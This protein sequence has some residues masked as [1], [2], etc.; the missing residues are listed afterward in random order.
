MKADDQ[1]V[2]VK[3]KAPHPPAKWVPALTFPGHP[4]TVR[5]SR[6]FEL[7]LRARVREVFS[8]ILQ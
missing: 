7:S 3:H 2:V 8:G 4:I 5:A 6:R 1:L